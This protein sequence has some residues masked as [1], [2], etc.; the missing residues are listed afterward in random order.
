MID[1]LRVTVAAKRTA[2]RLVIAHH[3]LHRKPPITYSFGLET[4]ERTVGIVTFGTPASRQLQKS[5]CAAD[6]GCVIELNRLWVCDTMPRNT[7]TWFLARSLAALPP[8]IVISY[9]DTGYGHEGVVYRAANFRYAGWTDMERKTPRFDYATPE[10]AAVDTLFGMTIG[11]AAHSRDAT[12]NG[13]GKELGRVSRSK[14]NKYW[15]CTGNARDR[16]RLAKLCDWP[17]LSWKPD[18]L[19]LFSHS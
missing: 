16:K 4:T 2:V 11:V 18:P 10:P 8:L 5:A 3:Y 7:E 13:I 9:S 15:I 17:S 14:K 19:G 6:P 12:R 1:G